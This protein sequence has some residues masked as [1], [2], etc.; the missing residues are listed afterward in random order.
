MWKRQCIV[1][2]W[3]WQWKWLR[4]SCQSVK[5]TDKIAVTISTHNIALKRCE[6]DRQYIVS[7]FHYPKPKD[8]LRKIT[9]NITVIILTDNMA[10]KGHEKDS[11]CI[12][13]QR[14]WLTIYCQSFSLSKNQRSFAENDLLFRGKWPATHWM[15]FLF[16]SHF[17]QKRPVNSGSLAENDLRLKAFCGFSQPFM[18]NLTSYGVATISRLLQIT[19]LFCKRAL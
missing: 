18:N 11:Q 14:K 3:K 2:Q 15:P 10:V 9:D 5:M 17:P 8:L 7:H 13:S 12:V 6:N 19:G 16:I 1:R 4:I